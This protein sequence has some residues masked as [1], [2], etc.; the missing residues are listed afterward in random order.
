MGPTASGKTLVAEHIARKLEAQL[1]S[2][3]AFHVY[4]GLN[5]GTN[6]PSNVADYELLNVVDATEAFSAGQWLEMARATVE[7]LWKKQQSVVVVGG[8]GLHIRA[9][10]EGWSEMSEPDP[11]LHAELIHRLDTHGVSELA[12]EL[13]QVAP[14]V[15]AAIDLQNPRRVIRALEKLATQR[16]AKPNTVPPFRKVKLGIQVDVAQLNQR[17]EERAAQM[18][19]AGWKQEVLDLQQNNVAETCQSMRAIGYHAVAQWAHG[20]LTFEDAL[21]EIALQTV[22]YAKRQRTWMRSEPA[23][24]MLQTQGPIE[25]MSDALQHELEFIFNASAD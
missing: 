10:F 19:E 24:R 6:K 7:N 1:I 21:K 4:R 20:Q 2:A 3:D 15:A 8:T 5:I 22:Q 13:T 16:N 23:L 25:Q 11:A 18:L 14:E 9:L 12:R 17:I